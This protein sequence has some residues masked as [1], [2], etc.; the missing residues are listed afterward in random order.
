MVES[1]LK[2]IM[3]VTNRKK[4][5]KLFNFGLLFHLNKCWSCNNKNFEM[6]FESVPC[7]N[8]I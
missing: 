2:I 8:N 7:Y 3:L 6:F 4:K 5:Q 1:N